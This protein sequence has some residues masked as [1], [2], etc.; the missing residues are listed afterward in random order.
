MIVD[1][2]TDSKDIKPDKILIEENI[3]LRNKY[4]QILNEIKMLKSKTKDYNLQK[5]KLD[6]LEKK[7]KKLETENDKK[8]LEITKLQNINKKLKNDYDLLE[9]ST[10]S[11][12]HLSDD[13]SSLIKDSKTIQ[14]VNLQNANKKIKTDHISNDNVANQDF[15][16]ALDFEKIKQQ[17]TKLE[18]SNTHL[19]N[20]Y[21]N[22][23]KTY[24]STADENKKLLA[25][26]NSHNIKLNAIA[27]ENT[28]LINE[29]K[30]KHEKEMT[31]LKTIMINKCDLV[32]DKNSKLEEQ[33]KELTIENKLIKKNNSDN[34]HLVNENKTLV[35][36]NKRLG[37]INKDLENTIKMFRNKRD[38]KQKHKKTSKE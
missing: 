29:I 8:N 2:Y 7:N 17:N 4:N 37:I 5:D 3:V 31:D 27:N 19:S 24:N 21:K 14:N 16:L 30:A 10:N 36:E 9:K 26:N 15:S 32:N 12:N 35:D 23:L 1:D 6:N 33:I 38:F 34:E 20:L 13:K 25:Q 11:N 18:T 28:Y 22:L